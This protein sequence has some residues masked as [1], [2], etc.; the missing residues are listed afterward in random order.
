MKQAFFTSGEFAEFCNTTKETLRHYHNIGLLKPEKVAE[1]GYHYYSALQFCQFYLISTLKNAGCSLKKIQQYL[2]TSTLADF[3]KILEEQLDII[4]IEKQNLLRKECLLRHSIEKFELLRES[5]EVGKYHVSECETE[6][7][8]ITPIKLDIMSHVAWIEAVKEHL[9]YCKEHAFGE[10]Y[11][12]S[13]LMLYENLMNG[14]YLGGNSVCS[15]ISA[16]ERNKRLHI[17]PKGKYIKLLHQ[18]NSDI[19]KVYDEIKN[20]AKHNGYEICGNAYESEMSLYTANFDEN[21]IT[22][23]SVQ[24]K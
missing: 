19:P 5:S 6:Y 9:H 14:N 13:Y 7:F 21:Y 8:I 3:Q 12:L 11:Q 4:S 2:S 20:Y 18:G 10:E 16:P 15:K 23:V 17:K 1:N 24:I 22:E